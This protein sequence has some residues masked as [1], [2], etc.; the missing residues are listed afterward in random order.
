LIVINSLYFF[1]YNIPKNA[2]TLQSVIAEQKKSIVY[3]DAFL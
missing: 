3:S 2:V 1:N